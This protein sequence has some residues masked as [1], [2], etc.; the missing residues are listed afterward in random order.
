MP[1]S[2]YSAETRVLPTTASVLAGV[3][4]EYALQQ[5]ERKTCRL[6]RFK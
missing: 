4:H 5:G 2:R 3:P 1:G 6:L